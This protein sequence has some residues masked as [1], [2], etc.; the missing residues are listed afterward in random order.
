MP[1]RSALAFVALLLI[2]SASAKA[3]KNA[4]V[5]G[6]G[7][8][9]QSAPVLLSAPNSSAQALATLRV[10]DPLVIS[11]YPTHGYYKARTVSGQVGWIAVT[12]VGDL[13]ASPS[14]SPSPTPTAAPLLPPTPAPSVAPQVEENE[15]FPYEDVQPAE[16]AAPTAAAAP[17][18][19]GRRP[20]ELQV[21][22]GVQSLQSVIAFTQIGVNLY[23]SMPYFGLQFGVPVTDRIFL[24]LRLERLSKSSSEAGYDFSLSA[25]PITTGLSY[26]FLPSDIPVRLRGSL[27]FGVAFSTTLDATATND[28]A[29][30]L[31][32]LQTQAFT[33]MVKADFEIPVTRGFAFFAE[34]G[35]RFLDSSSIGPSKIVNGSGIFEQAGT[36]APIPLNFSGFFGGA[37]LAF[38]L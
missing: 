30:N 12:A 35:Y 33:E 7:N 9:A 8:G 14:P 13:P 1:A 19:A 4:Y 16:A 28:P 23:S 6:N 36:A 29:P 2:W 25:T 24:L 15:T 11:N 22:G 27:L 18:S 31:S 32:E 3:A 38:Y 37:G 10:G 21:F 17:A 26:S 20:I 34:G 5:V